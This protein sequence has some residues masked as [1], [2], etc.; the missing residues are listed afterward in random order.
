[1]ACVHKYLIPK[2]R[3]EP[4]LEV[5]G[6]Y[7]P[8]LLLD[9]RGDLFEH[10]H[11]ML[12]QQDIRDTN[13]NLVAPWQMQ[14]KFRPGTIVV[15]DTT[16]VCWHISAR[17][18]S[19]A[20]NVCITSLWNPCSHMLINVTT[21]PKVYQVQ[22]HRIQILHESEE[23]IE[24]LQIPTLPRKLEQNTLSFD[25]SPRKAPSSAFNAFGSPSKKARHM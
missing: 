17:G 13:D 8:N 1:M 2:T 21:I 20:R 18:M 11:A 25:T 14:D 10:K 5:G 6:L 7:N 24:E 19:K 12:V 16:L 3:I 9:H 22:A 4:V 15:M 23:P